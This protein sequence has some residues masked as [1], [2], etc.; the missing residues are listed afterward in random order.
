[1]KWIGRRQSGNVEDRR[2]SGGGGGF[3]GFGG[4][5]GGSRIPGGLFSKGGLIVVVIVV[6]IAWINGVNPLQLL[7]QTNTGGNTYSSDQN[8]TPSASE[9]E[10][11]AFVRVV[12]AD[13]ED[14]W[15]K[16][17]SDYR[18]PTLVMFTDYV[19]SA[20]GQ[21]SAATGP[22]YCPADEKVYIDL[23][24]YNDLKNKFGAPGDFAQAY[25][26]AHEVG[27]HIQHL[28]GISDKV[29]GLRQEQ[30]EAEA[31]A[32]SVR[33][34]LQADFL[35]GLWAHYAEEMNDVLDPGDIE[36][37]LT[38]ASAIGD[39]RLQKQARG[40]VTPD[41]FTHGTS[42][43]RMK[44]FKKGYDTGDMKQGDT[45]SISASEL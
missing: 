29:H 36:E 7:Q 20:C 42:E 38:A 34:E 17:F 11:A 22:F 23:S 27:H 26:I 25:V 32:M 39:D 15:N 12:L 35:A 33:L 31:N 19:E 16:Q 5:G 37:A 9:Q 41:S 21:A 28:M 40:Y 18:E 2:G 8:Y 1:M 3:G 30:S 13:T 45:F 24:F 44:W 10:L 43:Q 4:F 14:V 6:I